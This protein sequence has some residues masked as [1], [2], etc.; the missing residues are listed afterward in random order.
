M[1][2]LRFGSYS[3]ASTLAGT[4]S[5]S[6]RKSILRYCF[7]WP[8]PR[9]QTEISPWLLR[10]PVR[11]FGSRRLFSGVCLV[12]W[13]LSRTVI[14][15][16]DAVYGLKLFSPIAASCPAHLGGLHQPHIFTYCLTRTKNC[17]RLKVLRKLD[18]LFAFGQ[19]YVSLF[20]VAAIP[21]GLTSA[22]HFPNE[23]RGTHTGD[24]Y[25]ENLLH[26]FLD[27]RLGGFRG[28]FEDHRAVNF[29]YAQTFFGDD[30]AAN[31]LIMR[32]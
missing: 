31:N 26:R 19:F 21:F 30:R 14:T 20:P 15:R 5:L 32:G 28:N 8:A 7:L 13:F 17:L 16:L 24:F 4:P 2:A 22:A 29:F 23:I 12:I 9:C 1:L 6:R 27:L 3:M 10:R 25:I 11:F 18:H